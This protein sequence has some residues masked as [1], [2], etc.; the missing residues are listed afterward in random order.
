MPTINAEFT[1]RLYNVHAA[2]SQR[3]QGPLEDSTALPQRAVLHAVE[4]S[5]R[6]VCFE[7]TQN[8]RRRMAF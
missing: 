7:H 5:S 6:G 2:R 3:A 8:K 1:Q 4:T